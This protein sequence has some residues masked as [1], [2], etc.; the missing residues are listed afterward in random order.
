[1]LCV[2]DAETVGRL[3]KAGSPT[4]ASWWSAALAHPTRPWPSSASQAFE[5]DIAELCRG[6]GLVRDVMPDREMQ[7]RTPRSCGFLCLMTRTDARACRPVI[8]DPSRRPHPTC[9]YR[10]A[11]IPGRRGPAPAGLPRRRPRPASGPWPPPSAGRH[12]RHGRRCGAGRRPVDRRDRRMGRRCAPAR[13]GR[14]GRPPPRPRLLRHPAGAIIRRTLARLDPDALAAAVGAWLADRERARSRPATRWRRAVAVDG[15]TLR[16]ARTGAANGD[17]RPVH[18]LACMDHTTRAVLAQRQ[19]GGAPEEVTAFAPLLAP[20]VLDGTVVTTDA[21]Q[22]HPQAAWV[23]GHRETGAI[24]VGGQ[25]QP[26]HPAG[27][28]PAPALAP[29]PGAGPHPRPRPR[30]HRDPDPQGGL[31][32]PVRVPAC[33]P[34]PAGH[35][36]ERMP[37]RSAPAPL[38]APWPAC[39][40]WPSACC[41]GPGWSTSPPRCAA[42]PATRADPWPRSGSAWDETRRHDRTTEP[43]R[44][45]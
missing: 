35:P 25:G 10:P 45:R 12:P 34:G 31:G 44:R 40:T 21:L 38:P 22:T 41:A 8:P 1:M 39:A 42:T 20:L 28:L 15:K 3:G 33:R 37:P 36:Q 5:P 30:P 2:V 11:R 16:G 6:P 9:S 24:P 7:A 29:R 18:L 13:P 27:P 4:A 14:A 23:P 17:G 43:C 26:A 19:V 32:Q